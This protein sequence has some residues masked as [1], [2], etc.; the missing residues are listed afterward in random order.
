MLTELAQFQ[1]VKVFF[2]F[3][4]ILTMTITTLSNYSAL[5]TDIYFLYKKLTHAGE[6]TFIIYDYDIT[7]L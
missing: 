3:I 2:A 5:H 7:S 6:I 4:L 1:N